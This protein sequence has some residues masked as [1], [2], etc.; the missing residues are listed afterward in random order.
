MVFIGNSFRKV[1]RGQFSIKSRFRQRLFLLLGIEH[2]ALF[3]A[4]S[5][6]PQNLIVLRIPLSGAGERNR[7][8]NPLITNELL[9]H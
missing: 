2:P 7:T 6:N 8:S 5:K 4:Q 3:S 1:S 9:C